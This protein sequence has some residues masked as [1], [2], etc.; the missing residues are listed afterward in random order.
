MH[1]GCLKLLCA[2]I[3]LVFDMTN[4]ETLVGLVARH[5]CLG[6]TLF[7]GYQ[8]IDYSEG[9]MYSRWV[10]QPLGTSTDNVFAWNFDDQRHDWT[11][12]RYLHINLKLT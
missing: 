1:E 8:G 2:K 7:G 4:I 6:V 11:L 9:N 5:E 3:G 12:R 10:S